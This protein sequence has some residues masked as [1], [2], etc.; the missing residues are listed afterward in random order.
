MPKKVFRI[1]YGH[2]KDMLKAL[3]I[4]FIFYLVSNF[5][6]Y[7]FYAFLAKVL[8]LKAFICILLFHINSKFMLENF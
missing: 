8:P 4:F 5:F 6:F 2:A 1:E 3:W 7:Q